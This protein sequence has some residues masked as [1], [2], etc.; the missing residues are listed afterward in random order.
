MRTL[1]LPSTLASLFEGCK[2][3]DVTTAHFKTVNSQSL[4]VQLTD[5][6]VTANDVPSSESVIHLFDTVVMPS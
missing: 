2:A 3:E 4:D 6:K 1:I 5:V